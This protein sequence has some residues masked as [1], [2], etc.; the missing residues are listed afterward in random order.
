MTDKRT[1]GRA[2]VV[3]PR[4]PCASPAAPLAGIDR[5]L[6]GVLCSH[7]VVSQAQLARLF[8]EVPERTLRYRTRRLHEL[9]LTGRSRP[10][11]ECGSAPNHHWPTRRADC[12]MRGEPVP[13]GGERSA[14]N[15]LFLAHASALTGLYVALV[16][17]AGTAGL[18]LQIYCREGDAREEFESDGRARAL[19]PDAMVVLADAGGRQLGAFVEID[20][21]SMSHTRLCQKADLYAAYAGSEAW[22][23]R[24]LFLPA[25]LFLTTTDA[26]AGKFLAALSRALSHGPRRRGRRAFV[27]AGAGIAWEPERLLTDACLADLDGNTGL[28]L[29]DVLESARAPHERALAAQRE[30]EAAD[31]ARRR[32]LRE[33]PEAMRK[34]LADYSYALASYVHAL[35]AIGER[36]VELL[37]AGTGKLSMDEREVLRV[38]ACDLDQALPEPL[39][40]E[41]P[42]PGPGVHTEI[43]LLIEHYRREQ[44]CQLERLASSYGELLC[45][46]RARETLQ[47]D[48]LLDPATV[49]GLASVAERDAASRRQ[50]HERREA[51]LQWRE[52]AAQ[53]LVQSAGPLGRL[54]RRPQDFYT[55]LDRD[56]LRTCGSCGETIYPSPNDAREPHPSCHYCREP[57][58][59]K[60]YHLPSTIRTE[61]EEYE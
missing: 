13:R 43:A 31:E 53:R 33:N 59:T 22:H 16:T 2:R 44:T 51:Y 49:A 41:L 7:R 61:S 4:R 34:L 42:E 14:P 36:A 39:A 30:R 52:R 57:H 18:S 20:L 48:G 10:Y 27:A 3:R 37:C 47:A 60:P 45:L 25:L 11:R 40:H 5:R 54:T 38:I 8:P 55:Q 29:L 24:H 12:L 9:G 15:P 58:T 35:G 26:R 56:R 19:A 23:G 1:S 28:A 17:E 32:V 6:L 46:A 50:Q 21:G